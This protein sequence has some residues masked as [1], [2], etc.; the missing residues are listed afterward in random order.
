MKVRGQDYDQI[1]V[2]A[3]L[4]VA[5]QLGLGQNVCNTEECQV[6]GTVLSGSDFVVTSQFVHAFF[7]T[8]QH[9]NVSRNRH[10]SFV[11]SKGHGND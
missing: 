9:R 6:A 3:F 8:K 7:E 10:L 11:I 5:G 1:V 2:T 4:A